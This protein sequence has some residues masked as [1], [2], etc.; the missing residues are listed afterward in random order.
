MKSSIFAALALFTAAASPSNA[1]TCN[2]FEKLECVD[3]CQDAY[4]TD[5]AGFAACL[6]GCRAM[7]D[8]KNQG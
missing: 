8:I 4:P 2:E 5:N 3:A 7:C 1:F 6:T